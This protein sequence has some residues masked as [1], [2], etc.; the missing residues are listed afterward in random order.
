M[1]KKIDPLNKKK[2]GALSVTLAVTDMKSAIEFYTKG[3]GFKKRAVHKGPDGSL[4]HA[5]LTIRDCTL[6]LGPE[7]PGWSKSAKTLGASPSS[8]YLYVENADKAY[9]KALKHG[10]TPRMPVMD[11]FWGDRCGAFSD[12]EGYSW[13]VGTHIAEPTTREMNKK[14][15]EQMANM[16]PPQAAPPTAA[17]SAA[18][19]ATQG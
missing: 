11:M 18:G 6:M 19:S 15:K 7:M 8:L 17:A 5:E 14:M 2:Y 4:M 12:P 16:K 1:A 3:L 9:A 13:N 10:A